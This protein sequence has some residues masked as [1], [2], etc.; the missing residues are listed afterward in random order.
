MRTNE[1]WRCCEKFDQSFETILMPPEYKHYAKKVCRHCGH[2]LSWA[3][4]PK[5]EELYQQQQNQIKEIID[6]SDQFNQFE[7]NF[8]RTLTD[9]QRLSPK[10]IMFLNLIYN[11]IKK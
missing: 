4:N 2:F 8:A 7:L 6:H 5:S 10:Q 1:G 11:K 3:K 9:R